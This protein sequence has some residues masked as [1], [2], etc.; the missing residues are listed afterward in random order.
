MTFL[1]TASAGL[2]PFQDLSTFWRELH[3]IKAL[4]PHT[5]VRDG[6]QLA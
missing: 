3:A 5:L 6:P 1:A 2:N 4:N